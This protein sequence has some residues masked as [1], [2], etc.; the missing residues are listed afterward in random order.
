MSY[1]VLTPPR[2]RYQRSA[3][4]VILTLTSAIVCLASYGWP[5]LRDCR[6]AT[7]IAVMEMT[8]E[9]QL[10]AKA[11]VCQRDSKAEGCTAQNGMALISAIKQAQQAFQQAAAE[12]M[13]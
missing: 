10:F 11:L 5:R 13:E 12:C 8:M 2:R 6:L 3:M 7:R 4:L 9:E 1:V